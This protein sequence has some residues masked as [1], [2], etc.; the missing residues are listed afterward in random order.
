MA[1]KIE[2][3]RYW[4]PYRVME[5]SLRHLLLTQKPNSNKINQLEKSSDQLLGLSARKLKHC[6]QI[7]FKEENNDGSN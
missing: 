2:D 4:L 6:Q 7:S 3:P 1:N 5:L